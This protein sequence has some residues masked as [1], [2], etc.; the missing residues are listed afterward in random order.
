MDIMDNVSVRKSPKFNRL[1]FGDDN[2]L[3]LSNKHMQ[4][5]MDVYPLLEEALSM[6]TPTKET[7]QKPVITFD[8]I[9]GSTICVET[10]P[11]DEIVY[12]KRKG[13]KWKSRMVKNRTPTPSNKLTFVVKRCKNNIYRLLTAYVGGQSEREPDDTNIRTDEEYER[14]VEFWSNHALIYIEEDIAR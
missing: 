11:E 1:L 7:I 13:R 6:F 9:I 14:C 8:R 2:V 3:V 5:H 12:A 10:T 4:V